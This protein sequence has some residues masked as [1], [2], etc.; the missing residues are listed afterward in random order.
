MTDKELEVLAI[1]YLEFLLKIGEYYTPET[2]IEWLRGG[3]PE[4]TYDDDDRMYLAMQEAI[5][6]LVKY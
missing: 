2:R 1:S 6:R 5:D 3:F 4:A